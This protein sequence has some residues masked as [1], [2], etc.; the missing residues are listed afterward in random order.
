VENALIERR[1]ERRADPVLGALIDV[2]I[3]YRQNLGP[4]VA[5][6]LLRETGVPAAVAQRVLDQRAI[7]R[8]TTPRRRAAQP[9]SQEVL[10]ARA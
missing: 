2:A 9:A 8:S 10:R 5:A 3:A 7:V 1:G 4:E 6:A